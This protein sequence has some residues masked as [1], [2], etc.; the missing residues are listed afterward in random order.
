MTMIPALLCPK[1]GSYR[2][3]TC[4]LKWLKH[5]KSN[6]KHK[7]MPKIACD[8]C[9]TVYRRDGTDPQPY[10]T[11]FYENQSKNTPDNEYAEE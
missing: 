4:G 2:V 11:D 10:I 3:H 1:C 9:M 5:M 8:D 7:E 6:G